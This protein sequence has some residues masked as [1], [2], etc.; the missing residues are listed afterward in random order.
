MN[1]TLKQRP[2]WL[3]SGQDS[4]LTCS[5]VFVY[6]T[7][8]YCEICDSRLCSYCVAATVSTAIICTECRDADKDG[9][10]NGSTSVLERQTQA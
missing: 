2:W 9:P 3:E 5:Q 1:K 4:C 7:S 10:Q 6:E 8:Y